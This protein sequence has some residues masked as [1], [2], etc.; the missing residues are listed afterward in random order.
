MEIE[1]TLED[2]QL[3]R[4]LL[5]ANVSKEHIRKF[6]IPFILHMKE[7]GC[8]VDV[9]CRMDEPVPECDHAYDLPCNRNPFRG[10]I[11][12]SVFILRKALKE[13]KYDAVICNTLT[14]GMIARLA[15]KM[16]GSNAPKL[17]YINHGLHFFEGASLSRWIMG[18]PLEKMLAPL[19]DVL[20][21][22]NTADYQM[23]KKHLKTKAIERI[24][25]IG[26]NLD[27]FR[28]CNLNKD[29]KAELRHSI[30]LGE[31]DFVLTY[32]AEI[33][34]NKNQAML[35]ETF[36]IV[37]QTIP[38][39]KLLLVGPEHD[40]GKL[41]A[42]ADAKGL[43]GNVVF[44]GWRN[45]IPELL[46]ISDIYV[47]SSKSEG[48]G[49]NLIEAMACNLPVVASRNRGHAEI[50]QH[51][52]NGFLVEQ[53]DAKEMAKYVVQL[54]EDE[55]LR[56]SIVEQAQRDIVKFEVNSVIKEEEH[57][58]YSYIDKN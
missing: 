24:H 42:T 40:D 54:Y 12:K 13:N 7:K 35:L 41:R 53:G 36:R 57:I 5:V 50:I 44:L 9:A 16:L 18:Y 37:Q 26:V 47:A 25:G 19:T 43:I 31:D 15:K 51:E 28:N 21:T 32:V 48:L 23:A 33:N 10:G 39:V 46:N 1:K 34:D 2:K 3:H 56:N 45:D 8:V 20:V 4:F 52:Q 38:R 49:L 11:T 30:G 14:G 27:R 55:M 29:E 6:H 17:F 22:I 58:L